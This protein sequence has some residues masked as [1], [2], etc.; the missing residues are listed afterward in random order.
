[1]PMTD[2]QEILVDQ[3]TQRNAVR[4]RYAG[5]AERSM[6]CC[7]DESACCETTA[8][9][10]G[11]TQLGYQDDVL[12]RLPAGAKLSIGCGNPIAID[13]L[14]PGERVL[15]LGSG[16]GFDCFLAAEEVGQDGEVIGVDMT[17]EMVD[18]A[19]QTATESDY[20][21]VEFRLGEIESLPVANES[22]D[23][24]ISNCVINLSP[25]KPRVFDEAYRVLKPG[26]RLAV[27]DVVLTAEPPAGLR[28]DI[29][30]I[31]SCAGG[32]E[33]I[34]R[35]ESMLGAAGFVDIDIKP[36][37]DSADFIREWSADYPLEEFLVAASITGRK[38]D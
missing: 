3:E 24:I 16:A 15:D 11:P 31:A 12:D 18:R 25:A 9:A 38:P 26:G 14:A 19:R 10:D 7:G 20:R 2:D 1:M 36:K 37:A 17:P 33:S 13:G 4:E 23:V 21:N 27:S 29:D 5:F 34:D 32:A 22:I 8:S 30:A 28:E 35:L 6:E